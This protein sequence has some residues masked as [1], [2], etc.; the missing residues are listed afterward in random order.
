MSKRRFDEGQGDRPEPRPGTKGVPH[1]SGV[2][3][4]QV[5]DEVRR[6]DRALF[7]GGNGRPSWVVVER[8]LLHGE[9]REWVEGYASESPSF[10]DVLAALRN[11]HEERRTEA[12]ARR[13]TRGGVVVPF[14][15]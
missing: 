8:Y 15:R 4:R 6:M 13:S 3:P 7:D 2:V 5:L 12:E 1:E 9:H 10:A 11:D 14:R